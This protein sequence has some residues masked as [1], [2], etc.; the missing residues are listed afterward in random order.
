MA[1]SGEE[2]NALEFSGLADGSERAWSEHVWRLDDVARVVAGAL[3]READRRDREQA[4][5]G[6]D[7][8]SEVELQGLVGAALDAG[9]GVTLREQ[10][11]P[12]FGDWSTKESERERCDFVVL[13]D[14]ATR[15]VDPIE[16]RREA[17]RIEG[18]LFAEALGAPAHDEHA[19]EP[20]DA[21]WLE[22]KVV[23][24]FSEVDGVGGPNRAY[25]SQLAVCRKDV[26]KL[27]RDSLI[28]Q[29]ALVLE[30][31]GHTVEAIKEDLITF[32]HGCL[33]RSLPV[34]SPEVETF[35]I[36]ERIGNDAGL[37]AV[38]GVRGSSD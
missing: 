36:T 2:C 38:I 3:A 6:I 17:K 16:S 19:C 25:T 8:L 34:S 13:P 33:D 11:F 32:V 7:A 26:A 24:A 18:T 20:T 29:G 30:L 21:L 10:E 14:G 5:R 9:L 35:E 37:I 27:S 22:L 31:F 4:V 1:D 12:G 15:L 28:E 23:G